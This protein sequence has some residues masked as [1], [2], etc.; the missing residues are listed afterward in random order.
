MTTLSFVCLLIFIIL[1]F[2]GLRKRAD[3]F[4]PGRI[5]GLVWSLALGLAEFKFSR[6]QFEWSLDDYLKLM[7][8]VFAFIIGIYISFSRNI[9]KPFLTVKEIRQRIQTQGLNEKKL[10][11][12]IVIFFIAYAVSYL[13]EY[14]IEGYIPAF[15]PK[16]DKARI[17]FGVFG[18]HLIVGGIN[19]ILFLIVQYFVFVKAKKGKKILLALIFLIALLS[20]SLLVQRYNFFIVSFMILCMLYYS[21]KYIKFKS[22]LIFLAIVFGFLILIQTVRLA[23]Y[24]EYYFYVYAKMKYPIKYAVFT[25]PYMYIV[26]NL[27]NFVRSS[28]KIERFAYGYFTADFILALTGLKHWLAEYYN[29]VKFPTYIEGYNSFPFFWAYY[30]DFGLIGLAFIPF[31]LGYLISE[32]YYQLHRNPNLIN[33]ILYSIGFVVIVISYSSD[34]L[35]RLD[36]VFNF[37][38]ILLAQFIIR[39]NNRTF[40]FRNRF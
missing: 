35:T 20:F 34:P 4:S 25:E 29:L 17:L 38:I 5:L 31:I 8:A 7:L 2:T 32:F 10:Y 40:P 12:F 27:E 37:A 33:L 30:Y 15:T 36:M 18:L 11:W 26:M 16:P 6:L 24:A 14:F 23:Q 19:T 13:A 39:K 22:L 28:G 21:S 3:F 1:I 9:D